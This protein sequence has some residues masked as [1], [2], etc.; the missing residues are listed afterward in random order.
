M[1]RW[2]LLFIVLM[3]LVHASPVQVDCRP[4]NV[5]LGDVITYR[6]HINQSKHVSINI[7]SDWP[8]TGNLT[9]ISV[10]ESVKETWTRVYYF[11]AFTLDETW[12]PTLCVRINDRQYCLKSIPIH[13]RTSFEKNEQKKFLQSLKPQAH[14]AIHWVNYAILVLLMAALF[15]GSVYLFRR[16]KK[17]ISTDTPDPVSMLSAFEL[18]MNRLTKLQENEYVT[19]ASQKQLMFDLSHILRQ[20]L[21][22]KYHRPFM[23]QTTY[24]IGYSLPQIISS[25]F[26]KDVLSFLTLLDPVKYAK[27][28]L[29][30]NSIK[31][32][33]TL[34]SELIN[35]LEQSYGL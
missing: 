3:N 5:K 14:I 28:T 26:S 13:V 7:D 32:R 9:L 15:F 2:G 27:E 6:V 11:A 34:L 30:S 33:I 10:T 21:E 8:N 23:E 25:E 29:S 35:Q 19:E 31:G 4:Q 17:R 18:A 16:I 12:A 1:N 24:E 20:Y 22:S